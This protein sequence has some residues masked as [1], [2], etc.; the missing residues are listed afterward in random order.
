MKKKV[1]IKISGAK[2]LRH[3]KNVCTKVIEDALVCDDDYVSAV[4][5]FLVISD[6]L[7]SYDKEDVK[8][9][10]NDMQNL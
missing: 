10:K 9:A 1:E 5:L 2:F 3:L 4:L 7:E 8:D 6:A